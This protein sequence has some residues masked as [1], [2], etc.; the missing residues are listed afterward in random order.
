MKEVK[1]FLQNG[2]TDDDLK[3]MKSALAQS[4]ARRYETGFQK[5]AFIGRILDYNLPANYIEQQNKILQKITKEELKKAASQSIKPE[6]LNILLVGDRAKILEGVK[7][8]GYE[9]VELD[10]DGNKVAAKNVF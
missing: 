8:L 3:F 10:A 6:K 1:T 2:P 4:D 5:A 9:I 7:K